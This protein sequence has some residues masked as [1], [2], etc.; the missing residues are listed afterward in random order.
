MS[1]QGRSSRIAARRRASRGEETTAHN[2]RHA[3]GLDLDFGLSS[4][5]S[6]FRMLQEVDPELMAPSNSQLEGLSLELPVNFL[7]GGAHDAALAAAA[8]A[9][10]LP[11]GQV[12]AYV[13]NG[14]SLFDFD[15]DEGARFDD[16][17][18]DE[19][20]E[21]GQE[22]GAGRG[23][24]RD[25]ASSG[26]THRG[27]TAGHR[28]QRTN[29]GRG[30]SSHH[31]ILTDDPMLDLSD[32]QHSLLAAI[33]LASTAEP[34]TD[35]GKELMQP[36]LVAANAAVAANANAARS[37]RNSAQQ[38]NAAGNTVSFHQLHGAAG[39]GR[40]LRAAPAAA[41][42]VAA[43]AASAAAA[44]SKAGAPGET[45]AKRAKSLEEHRPFSRFGRPTSSNA[46]SSVDDFDDE[47]GHGGSSLDTERDERGVS[48]FSDLNLGVV[49][50]GGGPV[51]FFFV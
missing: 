30:S 16:E 24:G 5:N 28:S 48:F 13:S 38:Q 3:V 36:R 4:D 31:H 25:P 14:S 34:T 10:G 23:A 18:D 29:A 22:A 39:N 20:E 19:E 40:R 49:K 32:T 11:R 7:N 27:G 43:T 42:A 37:R 21:E 6:L 1:R 50:V 17:D 44:A 47:S 12:S 15:M 51:L 33:D 8:A 41:A 2:S 35:E 46:G 45:A 9:Q 26:A